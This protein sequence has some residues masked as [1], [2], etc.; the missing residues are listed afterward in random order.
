MLLLDIIVILAV[1]SLVMAAGY[2]LICL[3]KVL[4]KR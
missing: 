1:A 2:S 3:I 4:I